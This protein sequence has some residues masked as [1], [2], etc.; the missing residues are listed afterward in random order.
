MR[1]QTFYSPLHHLLFICRC[2]P[3]L[4]HSDFG[5]RCR[6][7]KSLDS[8]S[9][10]SLFPARG[11]VRCFG[12]AALRGISAT[13]S[14]TPRQKETTFSSRAAD[15]TESWEAKGCNQINVP[16]VIWLSA[17]SLFLSAHL[18]PVCCSVFSLCPPSICPSSCLFFNLPHPFQAPGHL[19]TLH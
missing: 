17:V 5:F 1:P 19:F 13:V 7:T 15:R 2:P 4:S 9:S 11:D 6:K 10:L 3:C 18:L 14:E 16:F 8:K 12:R